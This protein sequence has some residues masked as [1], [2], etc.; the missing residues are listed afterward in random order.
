[1]HRNLADL[2]NVIPGINVLFTLLPLHPVEQI[3][4]PSF[5]HNILKKYPDLDYEKK[6][7]SHDVRNEILESCVFKL[8]LFSHF[9]G[10]YCRR[11]GNLLFII[12]KQFVYP[13]L[14][15]RELKRKREK[16]IRKCESCIHRVKG[17]HY[18][19]TVAL[20]LS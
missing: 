18:T 11:V 7:T 1:M 3:T 2:Q 9:L 4:I 10:A 19:V 14:G 17:V 13:P 15:R 6:R 8:I 5:L 12:G 20:L 16:T